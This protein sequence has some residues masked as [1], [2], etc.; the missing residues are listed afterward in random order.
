M[1]GPRSSR[2]TRPDRDQPRHRPSAS[3]PPPHSPF[4]DFIPPLG[5]GFAGGPGGTFT[6]SPGGYS[7]ADPASVP[8]HIPSDPQG[9]LK[10]T[11]G[12]VKLLANSALVIV[13]W[14]HLIS[15]VS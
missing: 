5:G 9:V 7:S 15:L 3:H 1:T 2:S 12:A 8:I 14:V 10:D 6:G 13:R 4:E 11:H